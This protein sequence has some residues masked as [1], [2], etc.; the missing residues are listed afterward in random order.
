VTALLVYLAAFAVVVWLAWFWLHTWPLHA[1]EES[2]WR[3]YWRLVA[4]Y[5]RGKGLP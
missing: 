2:P 5:L 4:D 3:A 1:W